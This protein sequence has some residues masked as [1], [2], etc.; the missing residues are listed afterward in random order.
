M[1]ARSRERGELAIERTRAR[2]HGVADGALTFMPLDLANLSSV[3]QFAHD[4]QREFSSL[5][6][7]RVGR[8]D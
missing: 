5:D 2:V 3:K 6:G 4:V 7:A 1:A 8:V